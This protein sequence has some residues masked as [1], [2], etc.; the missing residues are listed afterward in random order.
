MSLH[1]NNSAATTNRTHTPP[2]FA[3]VCLDLL[4]ITANSS[5]GFAAALMSE[6]TSTKSPCRAAFLKNQ[7]NKTG[8]FHLTQDAAAVASTIFPCP[9]LSNEVFL[10]WPDIHPSFSGGVISEPFATHGRA[11]PCQAKAV[12]QGRADSSCRFHAEHRLYWTFLARH[13]DE[14]KCRRPS[15]QRASDGCLLSQS[16][17]LMA[18]HM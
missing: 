16:A 7:I 13:G 4:Q 5:G 18:C 14:C 9:C 12:G 6:S 10:R 11:V 15:P 1:Y 17:P 3:S 8:E 2:V